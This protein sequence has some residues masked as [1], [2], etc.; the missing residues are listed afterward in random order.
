MH[1]EFYSGIFRG[2]TL[3]LDLGIDGSVILKYILKEQ[4]VR[5]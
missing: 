5:A 2:R 3:L 4:S 1:T